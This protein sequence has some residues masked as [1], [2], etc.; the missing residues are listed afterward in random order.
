MKKHSFLQTTN[1]FLRSLIFT[2]VANITL[3]LYSFVC[4]AGAL[5][6]PLKYRYKIVVSYTLSILWLLKMICRVNYKIEGKENIPHDRPGVILSK[7]QSTWETFMI[8]S[9]FNQ[10]AIILKREL[11]WVPF[12]G[13]GLATVDPIAIDRGNTSSAM[14]QVISK[15]KQCL[16]EGR[17]ILIF[18]E[19]TRIPV[20]KVGKYRAGGAR[21]AVAAECPIVPIA[22]NAGLYWPRRKFIKQPGTVH[23]IIGPAIETAGRKPEE[24]LEQTKNWIEETVLTIPG[25]LA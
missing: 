11:L 2:I 10:P 17:W 18:P 19:G 3:I 20:G 24:V 1:L 16:A 25:K 13:W 23:M 7:H 8:P 4:T 5:I 21:L 9:L 15:G 22:H 14:E 12:F 6:L